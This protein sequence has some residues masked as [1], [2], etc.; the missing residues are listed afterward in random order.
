[1]KIPDFGYVPDSRIVWLVFGRGT[2]VD[3]FAKLVTKNGDQVLVANP[4][5]RESMSRGSPGL[6]SSS[7]ISE[8]SERSK[9]VTIN[10]RLSMI[11]CDSREIVEVK[12][13]VDCCLQLYG[14][15]DVVV[16][17]LCRQPEIYD[18]S[19]NNEN[20]QLKLEKIQNEQIQ[21]L[22][23]MEIEL[24][25]LFNIVK[26]SMP[27]LKRCFPAALEGSVEAVEPRRANHHNRRSYDDNINF[28]EESE[29]GSFTS[30]IEEDLSPKIICMS[31]TLGVQGMPNMTVESAV[32]RSV[33][34]FMACL[35]SESIEC[36]VKAVVLDMGLEAIDYDELSK[37]L[38]VIGHS[39]S[40]SPRIMA[41]DSALGIIKNRMRWLVEE[42][43]DWKYLY[44]D[45]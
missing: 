27:V 23:E 35:N 19:V 14:T 41:S 36:N 32:R 38:Y 25:G 30:S 7:N 5:C 9:L 3:A 21:I 24:L 40:P 31:N 10:D 18:L 8:A 15:L 11:T 4:P 29:N 2:E 17:W 37:T 33:E 20:P 43:E 44:E 12:E 28:E 22:Q 1:M 39:R 26:E 16:D 6:D 34:G 42:L 13:T 45:E